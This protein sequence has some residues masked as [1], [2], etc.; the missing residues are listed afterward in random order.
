MPGVSFFLLVVRKN[1]IDLAPVLLGR[2]AL[3]GPIRRVIQLIG[4]LRRPEAAHVAIEQIAFN[5]LAEPRRAAVA[6]GFPAGRKHQRA[7]VGD[8]RLGLLRR[9]TLLK[10]D[11]IFW[12]SV[13]WCALRAHG[14]TSGHAFHSR[15][16]P[17][18]RCEMLHDTFSGTSW[19]SNWL[20]NAG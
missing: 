11:H 1:Q 15:R 5:R 17:I 10:R 18:D 8:V 3:R 9:T 20:R 19:S 6:V 14:L 12:R 2:R 16:F 13:V 7:A 4:H